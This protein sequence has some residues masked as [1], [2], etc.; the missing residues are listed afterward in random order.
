MLKNTMMRTN[1]TMMPEHLKLAEE[2]GIGVEFQDFCRPEVLGNPIEYKQ[3]LD[4]AKRKIVPLNLPRSLHTPFRG[5]NPHAED[6][7]VRD[8]SRDMIRESLNTAGT[9]GC[10]L[11]VIHSVYNDQWSSSD[12]LDRAVER[13]VPFL[14][15]LLKESDL[16]LCL[17]NIHDPDPDFLIRLGRAVPHPR[18]GFCLD[19][20]HMS[21]FGKVPFRDWYQSLGNRTFHNHWHDN[22]GDQD[23]HLPLGEGRIDWQE[24][25][26]LQKSCCPDSSVAL[27]ISNGQGIRQSLKKLQTIGFHTAD[28]KSPSYH[29]R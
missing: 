6:P 3:R 20:G 10:S 12:D 13:F 9:L 8:R 27:E 11:V 28:G 2:T 16:L 22:A 23:T 24:I 21:A 17:E 19:T 14:E 25:T 29:L 15:L 7:W 1:K 4:Y 18:L 5:L 26:A